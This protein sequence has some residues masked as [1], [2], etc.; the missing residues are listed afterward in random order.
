MSQ[1]WHF[2]FTTNYKWSQQN[3]TKHSSSVVNK[4]YS[5]ISDMLYEVMLA[6]TLTHTHVQVPGNNKIPLLCPCVCVLQGSDKAMLMTLLLLI[7]V[8]ASAAVMATDDQHRWVS[9]TLTPSQM[10]HTHTNLVL[11]FRLIWIL[12][13]SH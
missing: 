13:Y 5:L 10:W 3:V 11:V 7:L 8:F 9:V 6:H 12:T 2:I 1:A 4:S